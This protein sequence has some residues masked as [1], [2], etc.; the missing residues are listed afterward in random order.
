M[1][2]VVLLV[3][4]DESMDREQERVCAAAALIGTEQQWSELEAKWVVRNGSI[5]FHAN[6]SESN[7]GEYK[8]LPDADN[9]ALYRDLTTLLAKSGLHGFGVAMDLKEQ[10]A[11]FP[12]FPNHWNYYK[13]VAHVVEFMKNY[14]KECHDI[15]EITFDNRRE[16]EFNFTL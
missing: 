9:K 12:T 8:N 6:K 7:G 2:A 10:K 3:Y 16:S 13:V 4:G 14:A 1:E 15:A 5:P 11:M